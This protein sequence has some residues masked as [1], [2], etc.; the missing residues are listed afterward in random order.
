M[1]SL[2]IFGLEFEKAIAIFEISALEFIKQQ[3]SVQ[4]F[5]NKTAL[6]EYFWA[7]HI[8]NYF[9]IEINTVDFF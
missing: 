1:H 8:Q 9:H 7:G 3:T 5:G 6:F 4:K 2:G